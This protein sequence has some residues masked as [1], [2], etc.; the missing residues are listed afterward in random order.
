MQKY[1]EKVSQLS[2]PAKKSMQQE[3]D[4]FEN[5]QNKNDS[6]A[7]LSESMKNDLDTF[8]NK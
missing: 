2:P 1:R 3:I 6:S 8:N 5:L 4:D 7:E